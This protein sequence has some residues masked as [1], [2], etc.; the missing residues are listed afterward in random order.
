MNTVLGTQFFHVDLFK[1]IR[2]LL[3]PNYNKFM[4]NYKKFLNLELSE[5]GDGKHNNTK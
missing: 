4:K 2:A 1:G 3:V 5:R